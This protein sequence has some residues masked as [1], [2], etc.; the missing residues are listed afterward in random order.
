M[1]I[2]MWNTGLCKILILLSTPTHIDY[3]YTGVLCQIPIDLNGTLREIFVMFNQ[4]WIC[5]LLAVS[6]FPTYV[7]IEALLT[8]AYDAPNGTR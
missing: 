7:T 1:S 5:T 8:W 4:H 2:P 3:T 6:T